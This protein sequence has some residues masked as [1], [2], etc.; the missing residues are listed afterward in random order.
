MRVVRVIAHRGANADAPENSLAAFRL[1]VS[2]GADGIECDLRLSADGVIVLSHDDVLTRSRGV[3]IK[4]NETTAADLAVHDVPTLTAM[5]AVVRGHV[6]I[7]NLELKEAVPPEL[8]AATIGPEPDGIVLSCF[9]TNVVARMRDALPQLPFWY[10]STT[11]T[12]DTVRDAVRLGCVAVHT[13]HDAVTPQ[14]C[15]LAAS[16]GLPVYVWTLNDPDR[17]RL[18]ASQGVVGI[19]TDTPA[20]IIAAVDA[21]NDESPQQET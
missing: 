8:L 13:R 15:A 6:S 2:Q 5:L 14:Y 19:T 11:G 12:S 10:L 16:A 7:I 21:M 4:T 1:A 20:R 3:A 18:L 17:A 9:D